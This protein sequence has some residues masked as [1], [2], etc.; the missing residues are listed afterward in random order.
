M[1][2]ILLVEDQKSYRESIPQKLNDH[3]FTIVTRVDELEEAV[4]KSH[5]LILLDCTIIGGDAWEWFAEKPMGTTPIILISAYSD[6][7]RSNEYRE[8][9]SAAN[10]V[11]KYPMRDFE[12]RLEM[13]VKK[14][15]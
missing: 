12:N 13:A 14:N 8:K 2:R 7:Q 4:K 1:M 11:C 6:I 9:L 3:K 15:L 10:T 5:D